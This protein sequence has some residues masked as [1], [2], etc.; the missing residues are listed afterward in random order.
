MTKRVEDLDCAADNLEHFF[1]EQQLLVTYVHSWLVLL[2]D[3]CSS[4]DSYR[5]MLGVFQRKFSQLH[6]DLLDAE[7]F[8]QVRC[9][10]I[11]ERLDQIRRLI[12]H[13]ILRFLGNDRIIDRVVDLVRHIPLLMIWPERNADS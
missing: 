1:F 5:D 12:A 4:R 3:G 2:G 13:K 10:P 11:G 6:C 7:S 8:E 9:E